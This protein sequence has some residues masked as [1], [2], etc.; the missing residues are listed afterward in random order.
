LATGAISV[1]ID[2]GGSVTENSDTSSGFFSNGVAPQGNHANW[3][4][5]SRRRGKRSA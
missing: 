1:R 5:L 2:F 3:L 4:T